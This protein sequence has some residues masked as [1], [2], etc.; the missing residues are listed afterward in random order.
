MNA[1]QT[2]PPKT[3]ED[4]SQDK[5]SVA[6]WAGTTQ[7]TRRDKRNDEE[8]GEVFTPSMPSNSFSKA[9]TEGEYELKAWPRKSGRFKSVVNTVR[10]FRSRTVHSAPAAF[11]GAENTENTLGPEEST[12]HVQGSQVEGREKPR[13]TS[14]VSKVN[15]IRKK[16]SFLKDRRQ[17][18]V[19]ESQLGVLYSSQDDMDGMAANGSK[20]RAMK[21][22][23]R[24]SSENLTGSTTF[25]S[26]QSPEKSFHSLPNSPIAATSSK[27][28]FKRFVGQRNSR[29]TA[30]CSSNSQ[31]SS[32]TQEK[33]PACDFNVLIL[34]ECPDCK[35]SQQEGQ[36]SSF[37]ERLIL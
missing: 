20:N 18:S 10:S 2:S 28:R 8:N 33:C 29:S 11:S 26:R 36:N 27:D 6:S 21:K 15:S 9:E 19:S 34:S 25:S 22:I 1:L 37:Q 35:A 17:R 13:N 7:T 23:I 31:G 32:T 5:R 4:L 14:S 24:R 3:S 12:G 16:F 30:S